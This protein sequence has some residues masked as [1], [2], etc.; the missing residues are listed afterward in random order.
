MVLLRWSLTNY[1]ILHGRR[2]SR[3][4]HDDPDDPDDL[5]DSDDDDVHDEGRKE[6][7]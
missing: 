3:E 2:P 4:R 6:S 1:T 5:D 7:S